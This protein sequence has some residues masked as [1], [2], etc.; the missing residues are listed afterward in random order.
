MNVTLESSNVHVTSVS[1]WG[2]VFTPSPSQNARTR[3][4]YVNTTGKWIEEQL[5]KAETKATG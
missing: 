3:E 1:S 5:R 4:D 2:M